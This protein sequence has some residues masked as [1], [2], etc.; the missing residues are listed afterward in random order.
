MGEFLTG[1]W[2]MVLTEPFVGEGGELVEVVLLSSV[3]K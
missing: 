1:K 3:F 2:I